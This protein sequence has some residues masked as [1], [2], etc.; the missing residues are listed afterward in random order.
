MDKN[1]L[2]DWESLFVQSNFIKASLQSVQNNRGH[3]VALET[4]GK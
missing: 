1:C 3:Y 4:L 2:V